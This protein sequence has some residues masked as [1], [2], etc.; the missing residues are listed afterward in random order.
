[1]EVVLIMFFLA[2]NNANFQFSTEKL[3]WKSYTIIELLFYIGQIELIDKREFVKPAPNKNFKT[4]IM[5]VAALKI[6]VAM[7]IY[8]F[9]AI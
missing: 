7:L 2:F 6:P 4:F 3:I 8:L 5:H 1:M 9:L